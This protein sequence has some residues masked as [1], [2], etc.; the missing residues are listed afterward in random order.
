MNEATSSTQPPTANSSRKFDKFPGVLPLDQLRNR[1]ALIKTNKGGI[2]IEFFGSEA[3]KAVSNFIFLAKNGFYDGLTFHRREEGF[4]IQGGD[5]AGNGSG[6]PGYQF[7]DEPVTRNYDRGI[8]AMANAGSNTNGSQF[9]I[10]LADN[11]TLPK[12]YTIFGK[13]TSGMNV[14][15]QIKVGDKMEKISIN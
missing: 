14:V 11:S 8:V 15:D 4:V 1:T 7:E 5:P 13:V 2:S 10:M 9:F 12:N 3:P 6:G